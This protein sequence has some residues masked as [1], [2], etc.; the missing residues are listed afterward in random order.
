[1]GIEIQTQHFQPSDFS[2]FATQ[3]QR[4]ADLLHHWFADHHFSRRKAIGGLELEAWLIDAQGLPQPHNDT[5][6][7]RANDP[8][9]VPELSKFNIE[10]NAPPQPLAGDGLRTFNASTAAAFVSTT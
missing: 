10:L 1:M 7:A 2:R 4:E 3:L 8:D 5:F 6:L 9:I